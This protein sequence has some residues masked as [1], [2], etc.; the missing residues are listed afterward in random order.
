MGQKVKHFFKSWRTTIEVI[1]AAVF[2]FTTA[3]NFTSKIIGRMDLFEQRF[4]INEKKAEECKSAV[5]CRL[6]KA[7]GRITAIETSLILHTGKLIVRR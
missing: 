2:M 5:E 6:D 4:S 7:E 3:S 1:A